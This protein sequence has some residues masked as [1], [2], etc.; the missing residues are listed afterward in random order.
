MKDKVE[1]LDRTGAVY[2]N[3]CQKHPD[4]DYVGETDRV[5]RE[6]LYEHRIIDHKTAKRS[7]SLHLD[8]EEQEE[9]PSGTRRST[10]NRTQIDYKAM[11]E[12]SNQILTEG[13]TEFSAHVAS[14]VH[15]K[16]QL[17]YSVLCSDDNWYRRGGQRGDSNTKNKTKT[18]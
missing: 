18:K 12:G 1:L 10:R 15:E 14:D 13:N 8:E 5:L 2:Y 9:I 17:K 6:R 3:Q 11:Q 16:K 4:C 7:A